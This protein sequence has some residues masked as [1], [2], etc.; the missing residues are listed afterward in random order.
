MTKL[1][2][3]TNSLKEEGITMICEAVQ[4]NKDTKIAE[5]DISKNQAGPGGAKA[6]AA[7]LA[8]TA[9]ITQVMPRLGRAFKH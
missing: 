2:L 5:L 6:V 7:M 4:N 9:S 3:G 8:V 1:L